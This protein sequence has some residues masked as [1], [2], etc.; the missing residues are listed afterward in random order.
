MGQSTSR[1]LCQWLPPALLGAP[2]WCYCTGH[3]QGRNSGVFMGG[4]MARKRRIRE[5]VIQ[6]FQ[7]T[8]K[9]MWP[10]FSQLHISKVGK[11][12]WSKIPDLKLWE[13]GALVEWRKGEDFLLHAILLSTLGLPLT[14]LG[15]AGV[16]WVKEDGSLLS[17]TVKADPCDDSNQN[18]VPHF[19]F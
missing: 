3:G 11:S 13:A 1:R 4:V 15:E 7:W 10:T 5:N 16:P 18:S 2:E 9:E 12:H 6:M 8:L 19:C 17:R 14:T